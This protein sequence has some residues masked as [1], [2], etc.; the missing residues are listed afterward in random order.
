MV[1]RNEDGEIR[2]DYLR[3]LPFIDE[4]L[5]ECKNGKELEWLNSEIIEILEARYEEFAER[6]GENYEKNL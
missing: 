4:M 2:L 5:E 3:F 6:I 1:Y